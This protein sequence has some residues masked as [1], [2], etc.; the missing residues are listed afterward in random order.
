MASL[1][2][3]LPNTYIGDRVANGRRAHKILLITLLLTSILSISIGP[4]NVSLWVAI[5]KLIMGLLTLNYALK[6]TYLAGE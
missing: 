1:S 2:G 5:Q 4:V 3:Y 6:E